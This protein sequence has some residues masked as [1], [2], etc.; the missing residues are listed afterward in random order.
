[1]NIS[2][3]ILDLGNNQNYL[4]VKLRQNGDFHIKIKKVYLENHNQAT[5]EWFDK[6]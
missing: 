6:K 3:N 4:I 2:L 5:K 1:M